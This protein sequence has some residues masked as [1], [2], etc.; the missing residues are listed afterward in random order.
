MTVKLE[1]VLATA[2]AVTLSLLGGWSPVLAGLLVLQCLDIASGIAAAGSAGR[3]SSK[4]GWRGLTKKVCTWIAIAL[5]AQV[6]TLLGAD[7][8]V[9][10]L[11]VSLRD[12]GAM[13]YCAVEAI[14]VAENLGE[15][16]VPL[17]QVLMDAVAVLKG[18]GERSE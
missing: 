16:G 2:L 12:G 7:F 15:A 6:E 18:K 10:G 8:Q 3:I 5:I 14:S 11:E 9:F 13:W 4:V 1:H 17:P